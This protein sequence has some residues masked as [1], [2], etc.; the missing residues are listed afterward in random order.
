LTG[1]FIFAAILIMCRYQTLYLNEQTGYA[2]RCKECEKIQIAYGN[3]VMTF[4]RSD[5]DV[6]HGWVK[7][8]RLDQQQPVSR[9]ART[10]MIPSPGHE[11]Q[12]LLSFSELNDFSEMLDATDSELQSLEL[13]KLFE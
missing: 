4:E 13:L 11:I 2:V 1:G 3:V 6:F 12:L 5:F 10:I 7:K 9:T 8:I